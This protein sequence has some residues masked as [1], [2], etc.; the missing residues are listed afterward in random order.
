M[1]SQELGE[2]SKLG[3]D[4]RFILRS[5]FSEVMKLGGMIPADIIRLF[6]MAYSK[7]R[8][9][10][11]LVELNTQIQNSG[12]ISSEIKEYFTTATAM[13]MSHLSEVSKLA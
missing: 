13:I 12:I 9:D 6:R 10:A 7:F 4:E 2:D 11:D 8:W 5:E 1:C 3:L